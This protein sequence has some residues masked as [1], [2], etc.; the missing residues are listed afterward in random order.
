MN[1]QNALSFDPQEW[2][3]I[4]DGL[5]QLPHRT[6]RKLIDKILAYFSQQK[7]GQETNGDN[8]D[9]PSKGE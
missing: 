3:I 9:E 1:Q 5:D 8:Q 7:G 6:S 2:Q 4:L